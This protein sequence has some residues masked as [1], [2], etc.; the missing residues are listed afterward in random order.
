MAFAHGG[1]FVLCDLD[2]HDGLCRSMCDGIDTVVVS[3]DC[4][5]APGG[6]C[7]WPVTVRA[8]N[9]AAVTALMARNRRGPEVAAQVLLYRAL[10]ADFDTESY[11]AYAT[12]YHNTWEAMMWTSTCPTR[13]T[14]PTRMPAQCTPNSPTCRRPSS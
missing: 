11:R 1:G 10:A 9:L 3:V 8:G 2:S 5:L 12:G 14:A 4:R 6:R 7:W 13:P